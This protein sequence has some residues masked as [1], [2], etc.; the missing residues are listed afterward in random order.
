MVVCDVFGVC[1]AFGE[2][3][4]AWWSVWFVSDKTFVDT[5]QNG[6]LLSILVACSKLCQ[7]I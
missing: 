2:L 7:G 5:R 6:Q 3:A 4:Y 1:S